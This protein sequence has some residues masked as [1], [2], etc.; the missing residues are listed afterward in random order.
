MVIKYN[1][2]LFISFLSLLFLFQGNNC[3]AEQKSV[4]SINWELLNLSNQQ[5]AR[6]KV[7]DLNWQETSWNLSSQIIQDKKKLRFILTDPFASDV[8]I[9][10]L[11]NQ[12]LV[13]QK[14]L[15]YSA[16]EN[17]LRKRNVLTFLQK[18]KL[19]K[20]LSKY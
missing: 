15:R 18:K 1:K 16:M 9:K 2:I 12:I 4:S 5:R 14:K 20:M 17:F 3:F 11:Q 19:H 8:E 7:L 13:N 10:N 6:I